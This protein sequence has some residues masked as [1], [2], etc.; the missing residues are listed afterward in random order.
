M[1]V[2]TTSN[3]LPRRLITVLLLISAGLAAAPAAFAQAWPAKPVRI[4][5]PYAPGGTIDITGRLMMAKL[6][7]A[8]GQPV[9]IDNRAGAAGTIGANMVAKAA[10]DGYTL[11][12]SSAS[13]L[14]TAQA[15]IKDMPFNALTD[16]TPMVLVARS[17]FVLVVNSRVPAKSLKELIALAKRYPGKLNY[18]TSGTGTT[19]HLVAELFNSAANVKTTHIPYKGSGLM[20]T[21]L[22]GGQV[23][24]AFDTIATTKPHIDSG[25]LRAI[26]ATMAKRPP[27]APEIPTFDEQGL[28]GFVGGSWVGFLGPANTPAPIVARVQADVIA[29]L[30][31]GLAEELARRGLDPAGLTAPQFADLI[32]TD[33]AKFTAVAQRAGVKPE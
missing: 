15:I 26:G 2:N 3:F 13:E 27:S 1:T 5:V 10:P 21:D 14:T 25:I 17:P 6:S 9:I 8:W 12:L 24:M 18:G 22:L 33:H 11:L 20:M 32:R 4:I 29:I 31:G 23:D 30:N 16:F 7:Q 19:T 28:K